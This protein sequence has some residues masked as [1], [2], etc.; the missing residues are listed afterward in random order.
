MK[1]KILKILN[2]LKLKLNWKV[3]NADQE[4]GK[5]VYIKAYYTF[6]RVWINKYFIYYNLQC[7]SFSKQDTWWW[8]F[9]TETF[10]EV[11]ERNS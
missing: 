6:T 5:R 1:F 2:I 9:V 8:S 3:Y 11:E 7:D 4:N 10:R